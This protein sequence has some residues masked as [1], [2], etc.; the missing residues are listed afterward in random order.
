MGSSLLNLDKA[1]SNFVAPSDFD[2]L[3]VRVITGSGTNILW[4]LTGKL[5]SAWVRVSPVEHS[6]P[7]IAKISPALTYSVSYMLLAC[8][9]TILETLTFLP[10]LSFHT[11]SPLLSLP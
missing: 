10:A 4:H 7:N 8:I 11:N 2:G 3:R 1:F 9:F 5:L 6:T